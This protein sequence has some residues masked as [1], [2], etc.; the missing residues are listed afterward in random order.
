MNSKYCWE[1]KAN[2][3]WSLLEQRE[4]CTTFGALGCNEITTPVTF[5]VP[6][7][8]LLLFLAMPMLA[9]GGI[10]F[11]ITNLQV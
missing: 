9:V 10:L 2:R 8:A 4:V 11:L 5:M 6:D 7:T 1:S 3:S